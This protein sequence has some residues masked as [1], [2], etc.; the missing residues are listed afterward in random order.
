M[1]W[2]EG[3]KFAFTIVD[4]TDNSQLRNIRPL[5]QFLERIGIRSTKTVWPYHTE[6]DHEYSNADTL[7]E[8]DYAAFVQWLQSSGFEIAYHGARGSSSERPV[9]LAGL[10]AY[11]EVLGN[12]PRIHVNHARNEDNL[13]WGHQYYP[14][15]LRWILLFRNQSEYNGKGHI[16]GLPWFWGDAAQKYIQYVR[17]FV[18]SDINTLKA[19]PYMPYHRRS[20]PY[21]NNWFSSSDAGQAQTCINLLSRDNI[22]RLEAE[23]GACILYTHFGN[24]G[25]YPPPPS[26]IISEAAAAAG[27]PLTGFCCYF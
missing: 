1:I 9:N 8:H 11:N 4:D 6:P 18:F 23:E 13:Y 3:K 27:S 10:Q 20:T 24:P 25:L 19:D 17:G 22:D 14:P 26:S 5:Y 15:L 16:K 21:V 2:P 7:Q 12:F